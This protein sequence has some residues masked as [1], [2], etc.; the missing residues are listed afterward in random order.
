MAFFTYGHTV[1]INKGP[2]S[3]YVRCVRDGPFWPEDRSSD[4]QTPADKP[5][6]V[7]DTRLGYL[8]QK[9][10]SGDTPLSWDE[11]KAHCRDLEL[12]GYTDWELPE[13]EA[14]RTIINYTMTAPASS[15]IFDTRWG[16]DQPYWS[17][18][19]WV[20]DPDLA[21][22]GVN[23]TYGWVMAY[24]K[25]DKKGFVRCALGEP[26]ALVALTIDKTGTGTGRETSDP[27][28]IDCGTNCLSQSANFAELTL[29]TLTAQADARTKFMGW[30]GGGCSGTEPCQFTMGSKPVTVTAGFEREAA[31]PAI[32]PRGL[33]LF[34]VAT[35]A[36]SVLAMRRR[37]TPS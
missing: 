29:I 34:A 13:I 15:S 24:A 30:S 21:S 35:V 2:E 20:E 28:R 9:G 25:S 37:R 10:D 16:I 4:F 23:F 18:S 11:A 22:W 32:S 5:D 26:G 1:T 33:V 17:S 6:T 31:V 19:V 8:W 7:L 14:L 36:A 27:T 3:C 12:D